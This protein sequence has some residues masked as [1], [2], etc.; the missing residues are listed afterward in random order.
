MGDEHTLYPFVHGISEIPPG[1]PP[2]MGQIHAR[3]ILKNP[4]K[5][6][7]HRIHHATA[8]ASNLAR[9]PRHH[10]DS[11]HIGFMH[12]IRAHH[13]DHHPVSEKSDQC[14]RSQPVGPCKQQVFGNRFRPQRGQQFIGFM[15]K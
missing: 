9:K 4:G 14:I 2:V 1:H 15:L 3:I 11:A 5:P 6:L 7:G 8:L 13:L 10:L 12:H